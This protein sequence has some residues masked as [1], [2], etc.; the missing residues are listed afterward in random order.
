MEEEGKGSN[1]HLIGRRRG[2]TRRKCSWKF[3]ALE[4]RVECS[5]RRI[6]NCKQDLKNKFTFKHYVSETA[7]SKRQREKALK[8]PDKIK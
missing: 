2:N 1:I 8:Q 5:E 3:S 7:K 6:I 4:V